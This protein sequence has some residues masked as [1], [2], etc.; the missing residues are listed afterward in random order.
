MYKN[1][2]ASMALT[3]VCFAG[4]SQAATLTADL[5]ATADNTGNFVGQTVGSVTVTY[6]DTA[7]VSLGALFA[8]SPVPGIID[9]FDFAATA[10]GQSFSD[11]NDD[12]AILFFDMQ[13]GVTGLSLAISEIDPLSPQAITNPAVL[14]FST[15]GD[16]FAIGTTG[17][18]I[19]VA[20]NDLPTTTNPI[21]LPA[22]AVLLL[23]GLVGTGVMARRRRRTA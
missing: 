14:G 8:T 16:F 22:S 3:A 7:D 10:F 19:N 9:D 15:L 6:S 13:G 2:L 12:N 23:T 11:V 4:A 20:V 1:F 5:I 21:P 18:G 17:F